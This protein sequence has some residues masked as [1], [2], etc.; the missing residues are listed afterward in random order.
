MYYVLFPVV[1]AATPETRWSGGTSSRPP[2]P[3]AMRIQQVRV[4]ARMGVTRGAPVRRST[5]LL[6]GYIVRTT[7]QCLWVLCSILLVL[8]S[9][10][11]IV[12]RNA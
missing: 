4:T 1:L 10:S 8:Q 5:I 2:E 3:E 7:R 9:P 11:T 6:I 12:Y